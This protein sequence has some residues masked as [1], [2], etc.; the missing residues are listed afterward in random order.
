MIGKIG[1]FGANARIKDNPVWQAR[2]GLQHLFPVVTRFVADA[3]ASLAYAF[4]RKGVF[5]VVHTDFVRVFLVW[6]DHDSDKGHGDG[7]RA[8]ILQQPDAEGNLPP[9][10]EKYF[11]PAGV[12]CV[13]GEGRRKGE[14]GGGGRGGG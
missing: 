2:T 13:T 4:V 9:K 11:L 8:D 10:Q 5:A 1:A 7:Y 6:T 3:V 14:G 12:I